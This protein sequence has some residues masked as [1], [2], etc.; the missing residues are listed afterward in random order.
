MF[1]KVGTTSTI[2]CTPENPTVLPG[3]TPGQRWNQRC[4]GASTGVKGEL[5]TS[6][7]YTFVGEEALDVG[8]TPVAAYHFHQDRTLSGAQT[9]TQVAELWFAKSNGMPLR[10]EHHYTVHSDS[11]IGKVTF[12]E[13]ARISALVAEPGA[14]IASA[15]A[16]RSVFSSRALS[17]RI[18]LRVVVVELLELGGVV[19]RAGHALD[20][21]PV[22]AEDHAV[23]AHV[24]RRPRATSSSQNGLIQMLRRNDSTGSSVK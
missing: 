11:P 13:T 16:G 1:A 3:M 24:A 4:T 20:V 12:T 17:R 15:H 5:T 21:R 10:D 7:P 23:G 8:G 6:G 14:M 19:E 2:K 22:G 18:L 9:G